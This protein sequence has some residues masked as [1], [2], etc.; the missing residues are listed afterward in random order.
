MIVQGKFQAK[1]LTKK[2]TNDGKVY[3]KLWIKD[4]YDDDLQVSFTDDL[5]G[6]LKQ[7]G[8]YNGYFDWGQYQKYQGY[9]VED[10]VKLV[11]VDE[12][13]ETDWNVSGTWNI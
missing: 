3:R 4:E 13:K 1:K 7:D 10:S 8:V 11:E 2:V 9:G 12:L 6:K 5:L